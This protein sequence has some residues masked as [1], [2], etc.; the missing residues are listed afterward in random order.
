[1]S[2]K[3]IVPVLLAAL[4]VTGGSIIVAGSATAGGLNSHRHQR[5]GRHSEE[6]LPTRTP[7]R[8]VVVIF[9]EN[10]SF[11]HYFG[12]YPHAANTDGQPFRPSG[13]TP[14]VDGLAPAT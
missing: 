1:M 6:W 11:D 3:R 4:A 2:R 10:V 8:H 13:F 7:I 9:G 12:T 5:F 14:P